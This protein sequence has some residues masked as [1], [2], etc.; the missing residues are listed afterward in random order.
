MHN[1]FTLNFCLEL[2]REIQVAVL[3]CSSKLTS[4]DIIARIVGIV[5]PLN[6]PVETA[7]IEKQ[8]RTLVFHL[9]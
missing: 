9:G 8:R 1:T 2:L 5:I 3:P 6:I 4:L 7:E